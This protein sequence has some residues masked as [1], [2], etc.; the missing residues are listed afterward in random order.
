MGDAK[1][2]T[3]FVKKPPLTI[4][5]EPAA[6]PAPFIPPISVEQIEIRGVRQNN[7]KGFDLDLPIGQLSVITGPSGSGKSSLAFDTVYAEGQRRYVE[8]FSP[9]TR[10]FLER[11]DKPKVDEIRGIPPAIAIEQANP[12]KSTR[13]TVGTIT[14][15]NDYLKLLMPRVV[16]AFCPSCGLQIRPETSRS[17]VDSF[18]SG[19]A[20]SMKSVLVTF[21]VPLPEKTVPAEFFGFLQQQGYLRV[22]IAGEIFRTDEPPPAGRLP[23]VVRVI[24]DRIAVNEENRSRLCEAVETALRFGKG[25]IGFIAEGSKQL[26][27]FSTGWHCAHCDIDIT[28]PSAGLFS[29][30]HPLGACPKC[31]GFGRT[32]AIDLERAIPDRELSLADGAVKPFQTESGGDCQRDLS[33]CAAV[34]EVDMKIPF[35]ELPA[36]DQRWVLYGERP[37]T[38]GTELWE[39]GLWYGVRGFFD[40]LESKAYKM[41][42][43]VLLSRYRTYAEC[44]D[45]NGG[46]YQPATLNFRFGGKTMPELMKL[47]IAD[48]HALF[49]PARVAANPASADSST[50]LLL[51]E[52]RSRLHFLLEVGLDYLSLDRPTRTLSGGEIERVNLTTCLGASLVNTLFVLDEPSVG[53]HPRDTGRLIRVLQSLRD[54]GNTL[55]VVEHEEAIIRAADNVVEIGPGRGEAGGQLVFSGRLETLLQ[56]VALAPGKPSKG[57]TAAGSLT[58]DYLTGRKSIPVPASRRKPTGFISI[59]GATE[60]NLRGI[61]VDFPLGVFACVSGVSGSGKSTLVHEVL[62]KKLLQEKGITEEGQPGACKKIIGAHRINQV[63]M[64]DQSP[65]SRTP[66]SS[67]AVYL[68]VFDAIRELFAATP[69]AM[70]RGLTASAFSFNSGTGRC[71]RCSGSG[72][73][74]IEMQFLS[75]VFVRCPECEGKRYQPEMLLHLLGGNDTEEGK[76]I[77]DVLSMTVSTAIL[78]FEKLGAKKVTGP[79]QVLEEVGLGYL[80]LGQPLNVLSGGESQR[81]KLVERLTLGTRGTGMAATTLLIFDEPTTGLHFDDV[82]LLLKAF[83]RLVEQGNSLLVIEHNLEVIKCADYLIDLGPEAGVHG[84]LLVAA[85]T[86]E[87]VMEVEASH[88]GRY[89]KEIGKPRTNEVSSR[90]AE[91]PFPKSANGRFGRK[92]EGSAGITVYGAREH[93]LKNITVTIPR[94]QMVIIT[95]LSGSGKSTL[96]FD[97]LFAEGQRRF[98]DSMSAYARQFVEQLEKPEVDLIVGLPPSVAIEQRITRGG[99]KST[100]ATVTEVYHFLRLLF[101]KLGTQYCPK[102]DLPVEKQ[103]LGAITRQVEAL[104]KKGRVRVLAPLVKARKGFHTD[105]AKWAVNHGFEELFVDGAFMRADQFQKLERFREHSIDVVIGAS[106]AKVNIQDLLKPALKIGKGTARIVDA[107]GRSTTVSTEMSCPGCGDSFEELDP[108]LFSFNSPHGWCDQCHGFGEIWKASVN[109]RLETAVELE[110]D[111]ERQHE[112]LDAGEAEICSGCHGARLNEVARHVRIRDVAIDTIAA[113]PARQ[114][115]VWASKQKFTGNQ[116]IIAADI[117]PEIMQRLKFMGE[118]GLDYLALG[119]SAKTLSGGESQRIRLSAQLGSNLRGVLYVL[120]EPTIGLHPRDNEKLLDT[121]EALKKKGNSLVIVEHDEE[122]MRRADTII[123]LGPRAGSGGGHVVAQGTMAEIQANPL[124]ATGRCLREPLQHPTRGTRRALGE[125]TRWIELEGATLHNLKGVDV[126]LPLGRLSVITGISGS[127]K[128]TL[129]RGILKPSIEALL[130]KKSAKGSVRGKK[131]GPYRALRGVEQIETVYEV[132]QSPIGKTSR[133]TPATYI[134]VFDE[135]RKLYAQVPLSRMRGYTASR[136]SFNS[137]GGRCETCAGQGVIKVEMNFL[138][139]SYVPCHD[140]EGKRYNGATLEVLYNDQSIGDVMAMTLEQAADFFRAITKIYRPLTL[141]CDTGLGYLT[142]GQPSPTLSGG[143]AQRL[144]LASELTRGLGRVQNARLRENR[145]L[146]ST[147]YLL[148]EPTIGLHMADVTELLKVLHRL[149][150]DGQTVIVIEH[151]LSVIAE[152]DYIVDIGPEAGENGGE[153]VAFGTPEEVAKSKR[154]RTAPFLRQTLAGG[155]LKPRQKK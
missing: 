1:V 103:S 81:L 143:E 151:N 121:L 94:D 69:D 43:R 55:L 47:S 49:D 93:N 95:G 110:M 52:V 33:R 85:G 6:A 145:E 22:W 36:A 59:K 88:T 58:A 41:H 82:A 23:A 5:P 66:R 89:L 123:D 35:A 4:A 135:I 114:A 118:V 21:G 83:D 111:A 29:F 18:F 3:F 34:R 79:L 141:L 84:G 19:H 28:P 127:G 142:L 71:E 149:V 133:S 9:Y 56:S 53:L 148:E 13:S 119:R 116:Q 63:V 107:R 7:L 92:S 108:R 64:V 136:F 42:V 62:F 90:I 104:A 72:F 117:L 122:T 105:V 147:L 10:Q 74:K 112:S 101:A 14:E 120:D 146:K 125:V 68:G 99:G 39:S 12:V 139:T 87:E 8:T 44:P 26:L 124:S 96:A 65:L 31:R 15:I 102:C 48:L 30:N 25:Q 100:V 109:P 75:D 130:K 91:T 132:D 70:A 60:H 54:K 40:W 27:P 115:L 152:A 38:P 80:T 97:I 106:G 57:K 50:E 144:K 129:M 138:P 98:L 155:E 32:I 11:M 76:S 16:E 51:G 73:E 61:D 46:R 134:K 20:A 45:C 67:P 37:G 24:Q 77:H 150:D 154:S 153:V 78:F 126:R 17:I 128:S 131:E 86:P 113:M 137:E 2:R 140:C